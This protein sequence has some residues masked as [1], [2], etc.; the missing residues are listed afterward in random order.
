MRFRQ[1][2]DEL[3]S[4]FQRHRYHFPGLHNR[5]PGEVVAG[6]RGTAGNRRVR[7]STYYLLYSGT[8]GPCTPEFYEGRGI[9]KLA[10]A[11]D[12]VILKNGASNRDRSS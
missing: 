1:P 11:S 10:D 7:S 6:G 8:F 5:F 2:Q 3:N 9:E 12:S 4:S